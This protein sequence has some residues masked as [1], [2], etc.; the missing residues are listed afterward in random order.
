[1]P[2]QNVFA[3][4]FQAG[5]TVVINGSGLFIYNGDPGPGN[6]LLAV[7]PIPRGTN[8]PPFYD[9]YGNYVPSG[10]TIYSASGP[11]A[12][13]YF[14]G[15]GPYG[16]Q[17]ESCPQGQGPANAWNPYA[18]F[19]NQFG[20]WRLNPGRLNLLETSLPTD[21][22][23]G[24]DNLFADT[25]GRPCWYTGGNNL[26]ANIWQLQRTQTDTTVITVPGTSTIPALF[27]KA[28]PTDPVNAIVAGTIYVLKAYVQGNTALTNIVISAN[29][30]GTLVTLATINGNFTGSLVSGAAFFGWVEL[31]VMILGSVTARVRVSGMLG[32][33]TIQSS[34]TSV[35]FAST[36][37]SQVL[38]QPTMGLA[39]NFASSNAAAQ[40]VC[41][42][43]TFMRRS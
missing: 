20:M 24:S 3:A 21:I 10:L 30:G 22:G 35:T 4:I 15:I 42:G 18:Y 14:L 11:V 43:S 29:L 13:N 34:S 17:L 40:L 2:W 37:T 36:S 27:T 32:S 23:A 12:P 7:L 19:V 33:G 25:S 38:P 28:Y 9:P 6:L 41:P 5:N 1:M 26:P 31:E 8:P 16:M 39:V